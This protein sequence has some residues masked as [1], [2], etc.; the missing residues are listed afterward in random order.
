MFWEDY[1]DA[2]DYL[3]TW[4]ETVR[5]A[6]WRSPHDVKEFYATVTIL[7]DSRVVFNI[8]GN[9]YRLVAMINYKRQWLF[10]RFIGTHEK[11]DQIDANTI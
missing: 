7:K 2:E 6:N 10:I 3:K 8:K 5:K 9:A 4:Y 11:Y 1:P